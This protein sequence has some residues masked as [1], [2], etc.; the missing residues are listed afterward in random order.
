MMREI[1]EAKLCVGV[2][3]TVIRDASIKFLHL[4]LI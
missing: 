4:R 1:I 2:D 3:T